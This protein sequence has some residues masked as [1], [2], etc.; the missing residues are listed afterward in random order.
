MTNLEGGFMRF[1][2]KIQSWFKKNKKYVLIGGTVILTII[3]T[4]VGFV[5]YNKNKMTLPKWLKIAT[6]Q[7]LDE[8]YEKMRVQFQK[9]GAKPFGMELISSEIGERGSKDWFVK[10]PPNIDPAFRWTDANR[11]DK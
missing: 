9:T 11:W 5:I 6:D 2:K 1:F 3:G 10:H 8:V 4:G 7:E